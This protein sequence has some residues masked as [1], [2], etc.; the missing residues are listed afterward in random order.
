MTP[1]RRRTHPA[2]QERLGVSG[3]FTLIEL[4]VALALGAMIAVVISI[5]SS[6]S[7]EAYQSTVQ[8]VEVYNRFRL[9][10]NT[11]QND[12]S[13]WIPTLELEFYVDGRGGQPR[14]FHWQ[15][16]EEV[17]DQSDSLGAGV[18]DGGIYREYDEY[19]C[20]LQRQYRS[21]EKHQVNR[22][23]S[24]PKL[25]DAYQAYYRT[26]T[27]VDGAVREANVEY[28]LVDTSRPPQ[29]WT[30]GV[31]PPP[32]N[33][34]PEN[35]K[36]LALYKVVRYYVI[37]ERT[38][39]QITK[40]PIQRRVV[41]VASCVTDFRIEY[42]VT[43]PFER[44][45]RPGFVTPE[46]DYRR[47]V[48]RVTQPDIA[49]KLVPAPPRT[50]Y[51]KQFGYGSMKL[52]RRDFPRATAYTSL[53]GDSQLRSKLGHQPMRF[54]FYRNPEISFAELNIGDR[55]Y[56]F[57]DS[58]LGI[59][60]ARGGGNVIGQMINFPAGDYTVKANIQGQLEFF[61]EIDCATW[62]GQDQPSINYKAA[63]IP[64]ALRITIRMVDEEG[65]NPKTM[66][67]VVWLRRKAR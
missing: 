49:E 43:N 47:P 30:N 12:F 46:E 6:S 37:D 19:A 21:V 62:K 15:P 52:Q 67:Q 65:E 18:V 1:P 26:M 24:E 45:A 16:Q 33:V 58:S 38:I 56:I 20:I 13:A 57:T 25:H 36:D 42:T 2:V 27:Y 8:Q 48:E 41:E 54:G 51:R 11:L 64:S 4:L 28:M 9:V 31:P 61:E 59:A 55:I 60:A 23:D 7:R 66:Q 14:D 5:I 3:G 29:E 35:V 50:A 22:G 34:Q 10:F 39:T 63:F 40:Y 44:S 17:A 53:W 32:V